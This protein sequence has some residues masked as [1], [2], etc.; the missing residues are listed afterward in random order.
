MSDSPTIARKSV[1]QLGCGV[2]QLRATII[3][4]YNS[5]SADDKENGEPKQRRQQPERWQQR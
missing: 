1:V 2:V 5:E 3:S 4:E